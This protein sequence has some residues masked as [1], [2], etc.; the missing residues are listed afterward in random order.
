[1]KSYRN[2]VFHRLRWLRVLLTATAI[3]GVRLQTVAFGACLPSDGVNSVTWH[4]QSTTK[5]GIAKVCAVSVVFLWALGLRALWANARHVTLTKV[6]ICKRRTLKLR[7]HCFQSHNLKR[8]LYQ[9]PRRARSQ[10]LHVLLK[11]NNL[12]P[13]LCPAQ[14]ML[15][16][17]CRHLWG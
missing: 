17:H 11:S 4:A 1:M 15:L 7:V 9:R 16:Q 2:T 6:S 13:Y 10:P 14:L 5:P 3:F 12:R 8:Q